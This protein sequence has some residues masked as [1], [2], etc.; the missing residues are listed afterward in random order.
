MTERYIPE[1]AV[2][3]LR[4][5]ILHARGHTSPASDASPHISAALVLAHRLLATAAPQPAPTDADILNALMFCDDS[6]RL[7]GGM[8]RD[9]APVGEVRRCVVGMVRYALE[10]FASTQSTPAPEPEGLREALEFYA[11]RK[12][13]ENGSVEIERGDGTYDDSIEILE[14]EGAVARQA[15]ARPAAAE[16]V[17]GKS[18]PFGLSVG[19][20]VLATKYGDGDPGD[21]WCVGF[22]DGLLPKVNGPRAMVADGSGKNFRGN[23]FRRVEPITEDE[24]RA[25]L[26]YPSE[27]TLPIWER[28]AKVRA[29]AS[30]DGEG[31]PMGD[32]NGMLRVDLENGAVMFVQNPT[33]AAEL[34]W[35]ARY[36]N[37]EHY[38]FQI[39]ALLAGYESLMDPNMRLGEAIRRLRI[40]RRE[41]KRALTDAA[42]QPDAGE[43]E[44]AMTD[45]RERLEASRDRMEAAGINAIL[46]F[47]NR[48]DDA[49]PEGPSTDS[50]W[51]DA[52]VWVASR[53]SGA[54]D[55]E[56]LY[57]IDPSVPEPG[58][59]HVWL[60]LEENDE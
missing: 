27:S 11:D 18:D 17:E 44:I 34:E 37:V 24:G 20:Y 14:D 31:S 4:E 54:T 15:L 57:Y 12:R 1:S 3:E 8:V 28:L 5:F 42:H 52:G 53:D 55:D 45:A 21:Q 51:I 32:D 47:P 33:A 7:V 6:V 58:R 13:Y 22:Y 26:A 59:Y 38:R 60:K 35:Q 49:M 2:R 46:G 16:G 23:G 25:L 41:Y 10:R 40:A 9:D 29:L 48:V 56:Q 43:E 50:G 39:A 30:D 36:G 19:D